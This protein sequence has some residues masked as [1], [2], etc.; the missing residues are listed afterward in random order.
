M[1]IDRQKRKDLSEK[2]RAKFMRSQQKIFDAIFD[3]A[4]KIMKT[5]VKIA[6]SA[7]QKIEE[8]AWGDYRKEVALAKEA[9]SLIS[10]PA[11]AVLRTH[12]ES[13]KKTYEAEI[14]RDD[15]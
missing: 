3:P 4:L 14:Y 12:Y 5:R 7:R 1:E 9:L 11:R 15:D 2:A 10:R 13:S 6:R 8:E